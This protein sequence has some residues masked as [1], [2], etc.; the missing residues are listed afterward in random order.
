MGIPDE[1]MCPITT[2][3]MVDP[4]LAAD[5][6]NYEKTAL[7]QWFETSSMS[8]MT[9]AQLVHKHANKNFSLQRAIHTYLRTTAAALKAQQTHAEDE[10]KIDP[11]V[12]A[13]VQQPEA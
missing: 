2:S 5:G 3:V 1:Y 10:Q 11:V 13:P 8:P 4:V 7:E 6:Y 9:G 12:L